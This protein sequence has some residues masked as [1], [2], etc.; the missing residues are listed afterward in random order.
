[1]R[2]HGCAHG[3]GVSNLMVFIRPEHNTVPN[4]ERAACD[5]GAVAKKID[6]TTAAKSSPAFINAA[7]EALILARQIIGH[8]CVAQLPKLVDNDTKDNIEQQNQYNNVE[9]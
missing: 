1:M 8:L 6:F 4:V 3:K 2:K 9:Q 7:Y 5:A